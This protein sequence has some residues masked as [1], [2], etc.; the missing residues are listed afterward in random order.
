MKPKMDA[1]PPE[2]VPAPRHE[3]APA[4]QRGDDGELTSYASIR[5]TRWLLNAYY[6]LIWRILGRN[7]IISP[8]LVMRWFLPAFA[9]SPPCH[10]FAG[11]RSTR[12]RRTCHPRRSTLV[13]SAAAK[14][15]LRDRCRVSRHSRYRRRLCFEG[16]AQAGWDAAQKRNSRIQGTALTRSCWVMPQSIAR[17]RS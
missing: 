3:F 13:R 2:C 14:R 1:V 15:V 8:F 11:S 12:G 5:S 10:T 7:R 6:G 16:L 4:H 9:G 17:L